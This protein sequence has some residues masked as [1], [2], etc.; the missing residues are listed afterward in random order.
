MYGAMANGHKGVKLVAMN[1]YWAPQNRLALVYLG[2]MLAAFGLW[3]E[4]L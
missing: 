2:V 1:D 3:R 4:V